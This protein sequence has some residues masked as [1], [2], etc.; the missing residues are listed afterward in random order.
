MEV[1]AGPAD[2]EDDV[3]RALSRLQS[4]RREALREA[5]AD[6]EPESVRAEEGGEPVIDVP[7]MPVAEAAG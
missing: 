5:A 7:A 2:D 6:A 4:E 3:A 1:E